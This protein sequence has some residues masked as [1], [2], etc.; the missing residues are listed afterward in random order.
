MRRSNLVSYSLALAIAVSSTACDDGAPLAMGDDGGSDGGA[1]DASSEGGPSDAS[2]SDAST[3]LTPGL[4]VSPL[5]GTVGEPNQVAT[6]SVVLSTAPTADVGVTVTSSL[7]TQA[8]VY[9]A[10][11]VFTSSNWATPHTVSL[12]PINDPDVDG[13]VAFSVT[14]GS[15]VSGDPA[16][17]GLPSRKLDFFV[18]DD[19]VAGVVAGAIEGT[20]CDRAGASVRFPVRLSSRPASNVTL[21]VQSPPFGEA[22]VSPAPLFFTPANWNVVQWLTVEYLLGDRSADGSFNVGFGPATTTDLWYANATFTPVV[23]PVCDSGAADVLVRAVGGGPLATPLFTGE[24]GLAVTLEVSL[25]AQPTGPVTVSVASSEPNEASVSA[26]TLTFTPVDWNTPQTLTV[27]GL[28]DAVVDPARSFVVRFDPSSSDVRYR[29][30]PTLEVAGVNHPAPTNVAF[31][32]ALVASDN[33]AIGMCTDD[34]LTDANGTSS[35]CMLVGTGTNVLPKAEIDLGNPFSDPVIT[36]DCSV[37]DTYPD[38]PVLEVRSTPY[39]PW[40]PVAYSNSTAVP[41]AGSVRYVRITGTLGNV[42]LGNPGGMFV[43]SDLTVVA[44]RE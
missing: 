26:A 37:S 22:G 12:H 10:S 39:E 36:L 23:V 41:Y 15:T 19:D 4:V 18:G 31:G 21:A 28:D 11:L 29:G 34:S 6:F 43:C 14:L 2:A 7:P 20:L 25:G 16:Y 40:V 13:A 3:P 17:A 27:T 35:S 8:T 32:R 38:W 33:L 1:G 24:E 42:S 5:V 30:L 44:R 9:P